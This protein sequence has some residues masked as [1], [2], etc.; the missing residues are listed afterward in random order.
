MSKIRIVMVLAFVLLSSTSA[1]AV[2]SFKVFHYSSASFT[3]VV[4]AT[5]DP[6][7]DCPEEDLWWQWGSASHFRKYWSYPEC[8]EGGTPDVGCTVYSNGVWSSVPCP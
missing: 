2:G 8:E 3:T 1:F 6:S 7:W 4:G 5:Y